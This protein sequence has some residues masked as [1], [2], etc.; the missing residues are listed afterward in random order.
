MIL[1]F[2]DLF[3]FIGDRERLTLKKCILLSGKAFP[4][5]FITH[6][7]NVL[8]SKYSIKQWVDPDFFFEDP[9]N[10][11]LEENILFYSTLFCIFQS[12]SVSPR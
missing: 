1:S 11:Q 2:L 5:F 8:A 3:Q 7:K 10:S 9:F 6:L 12:S 4:A